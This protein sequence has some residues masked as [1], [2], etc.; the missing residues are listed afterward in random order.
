MDV[1]RAAGGIVL[2][3]GKVAVVHR[4][5]YDDWSFP[6]GKLDD[7]ES[8]EDA[9]IREVEEE[10]GLTC[11]LGQFVDEI[12]YRLDN[13]GRKVVR[14][15][16]MTVVSGGIEDREPTQEVD[17]I[18]WVPVEDAADRLSYPVDAE[19]LGHAIGG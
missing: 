1:I 6:K 5:K 13:G 9:A 17:L 14:F 16:L 11:V 3:D 18:E 19:L 4:P 12:E 7:E 8:F 10:T 2:H 15:W